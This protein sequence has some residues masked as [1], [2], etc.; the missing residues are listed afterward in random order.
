MLIY[1]FLLFSLI[2]SLDG[3]VLA[4]G[5]ESYSIHDFFSRY[6][7]KQWERADGTQKEKMFD[8]FIYA[9]S[10]LNKKAKERSTDGQ[11]KTD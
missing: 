5:G 2:Y 11:S 8:D 1:L 7:K 6:P 3:T 10:E 4:V 9:M